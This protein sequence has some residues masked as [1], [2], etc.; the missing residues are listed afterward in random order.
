MF[1]YSCIHIRCPLHASHIQAL[2]ST[3]LVAI[4]IDV[5]HTTLICQCDIPNMSLRERWLLIELVH[6]HQYILVSTCHRHVQTYIQV[7]RQGLLAS[8]GTLVAATA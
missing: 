8:S 5:L 4:A 3:L 7:H 2:F 6:K 1:K